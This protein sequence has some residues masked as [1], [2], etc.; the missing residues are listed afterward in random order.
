MK[1]FVSLIF[2]ALVYGKSEQIYV[3]S[4]K[5]ICSINASVFSVDPGLSNKDSAEILL[6]TESSVT[7]CKKMSKA[8]VFRGLTIRDEFSQPE[9]KQLELGRTVVDK[10]NFFYGHAN[11]KFYDGFEFNIQNLNETMVGRLLKERSKNQQFSLAMD[12][13][14]WPKVASVIK[15]HATKIHHIVLR[16]VASKESLETFKKATNDNR[17]LAF[18]VRGWFDGADVKK[19]AKAASEYANRKVGYSIYLENQAGA[20]IS[21]IGDL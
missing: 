3:R 19:I 20:D 5:D 21:Y 13:D 7:D 2:A 10:I 17:E 9:I 12:V 6:T 16:V 11:F 1:Y 4:T 15:M 8:K 18:S 14:K